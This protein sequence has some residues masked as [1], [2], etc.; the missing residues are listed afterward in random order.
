MSMSHKAFA[1]D[2]NAFDGDLAPILLD[3]LDADDGAE[4]AEFIDQERERLTDPYNGDP[5]PADWRGL[6]EGG[7]VQELADFALTRYYRVRE[8]HGIGPAWIGLSE[9]LTDDQLRLLLGAPFGA[10]RQLLDPGRL[11]AYFQSPEMV[12]ASLTALAGVTA[13]EVR[14]FQELLA[15]CTAGQ[16]GVYVTF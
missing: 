4:L 12:R 1:F 3:A 9:A 13:E 7:D 16:L 14:S 8:E 10:G 6:L 2:W 5:L 11:G 15:A